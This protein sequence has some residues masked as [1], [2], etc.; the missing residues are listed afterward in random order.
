MFQDRGYAVIL[1]DN[2][3]ES[4]LFLGNIGGAVVCFL[5]TMCYCTVCRVKGVNSTMLSSFALLAGYWTFS[6]IME[7]ISSAAATVCVCFAE[8]PNIFQVNILAESPY[9]T[10]SSLHLASLLTD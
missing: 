9:L 7:N 2:I 5:I 6:L 8:K 1:T 10:F 4:V 3:I